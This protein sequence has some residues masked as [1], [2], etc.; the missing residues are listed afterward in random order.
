MKDLILLGHRSPVLL[1]HGL[2]GN[3]MELQ[4]L[5]QRLHSAGHTVSVPYL[6]GYGQRESDRMPIGRWDQW[7]KMAMARLER[8]VSSH[9]P[10]VV[11]GICIGADLALRLADRVAEQVSG[12]VLISTTLFYDGWNLPWYRWMLPVAG[13]TPLKHLYSLRE[14]D[15]YGVKNIRIRSWIARQME[16]T[17]NSEAG[18]RDLPLPAL[19]QAYKLMQLVRASLPAIRQPALILHAAEDEVASLRSPN[20]L[21]SRLGSP[22]IRK[23]V[24]TDSYHMLTLDNDR[25]AVARA[26][27][28]FIRELEHASNS[29][30][31]CFA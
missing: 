2:R 9:G 10:A 1:L 31:K 3:P 21:A 12:L 15:P 23:I 28:D 20:L 6:P 24:F 5:A 14:K 27:I 13:A 29:D 16:N 25:E 19:Y 11:G 18:A 7:E 30:A 26:S 22:I 17:G 4:L 8:L